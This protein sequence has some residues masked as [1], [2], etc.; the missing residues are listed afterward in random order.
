[1]AFSF[2]ALLLV[3]LMEVK[4]FTAAHIICSLG[5]AASFI[6]V[7]WYGGTFQSPALTAP[8]ATP[9]VL[10][11]FLGNKSGAAFTATFDPWLYV[12]QQ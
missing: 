11:V 1:M 3:A 9:L 7:F 12:S 6:L 2:G 4:I 10:S 8:L 5:F